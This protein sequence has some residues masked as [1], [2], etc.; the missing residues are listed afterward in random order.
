MGRL[1]G[2]IAFFIMTSVGPAFTQTEM[3]DYEG[4]WE[5]VFAGPDVFRF[6]VLLKPLENEEGDLTISNGQYVVRRIGKYQTGGMIAIE[7]GDGLSFL[8]L[9]P[10][11]KGMSAFITGGILKH[12]VQ[13]QPLSDGSY[14]GTWSP[15]MTLRLSPLNFFLEVGNVEGENY[16]AFPFWGDQRFTGTFAGNFQ[17]HEDQLNFQDFKTGMR[18]HGRLLPNAIQLDLSF[19]GS[20]FTTVEFRRSE[21]EWQF[22]PEESSVNPG[23][24]APVDMSDGWQVGKLSPSGPAVKLLQQMSEK[25]LSGDLPNIH[26]VL[27]AQNGQLL[28]ERYFQGFKANT[29]H[30]QRSV[31]KSFGAAMVGIAMEEGLLKSPDQPIYE[32]L[33]PQYQY[34]KD[35]KKSGITLRHL[36]TMSSGLD[37]IDFGIQRNSA[38][39]EGNYQ[40]T[41][42]WTKTI[43]EAP[44]IN[45]P[46]IRSNYGSA[47]P[48]LLGVA[49]EFVTK[50][51][52]EIY[53][54]RRL[55]SPLGIENY[56]LQ[57]DR[58]GRPYFG[59]GW[60]FTPRDMLKFGQ[61]H[62][63]Q[64]RWSDKQVVTKEWS[65]AVLARHHRLDNANDKNEYGFLWWHRDYVI[66]DRV[67]ASIEARGSGGQYI[68][69]IPS[70][71]L[72]AAITSGN[73][74]NGKFM[75]PEELMQNYL[76]PAILVNR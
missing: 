32:V 51:P 54:D 58:V 40:Q 67:F 24:V 23:Y 69:V 59:G 63:N 74:R 13:L 22:G 3:K 31:A 73:F 9:A 19:A 43:L 39:S 49:V 25:I 76:L 61:L 37:A 27:V 2:F 11:S 68:F 35:E 33:P 45:D 38:A 65:E 62:L 14:R 46:G 5:G 66:G 48:H 16:T 57:T 34:T 50:E 47:N 36:L 55:M 29:A 52:L 64:G 28:F 20:V 41:A 56:I 8:G 17:K 1:F 44:M 42:D 4:R 6:E 7:L 71:N 10:D 30:D 60:Y 15:L 12:H 72:T 21:S 18:F 75:L 70:L 53:M 26:A